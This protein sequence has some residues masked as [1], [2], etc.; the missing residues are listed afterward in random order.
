MSSCSMSSFC[1]ILS[2][3]IGNFYGLGTS[4]ADLFVDNAISQAL[5]R[6]DRVVG[7]QDFAF[8]DFGP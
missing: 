6:N 5:D 7:P 4:L 8:V 2:N 3:L 1:Q